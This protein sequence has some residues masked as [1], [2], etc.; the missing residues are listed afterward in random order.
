MTAAIIDT[1]V[2]FRVVIFQITHSGLPKLSVAQKSSQ[3]GTT[4]VFGDCAAV[5]GGETR[6]AKE[7]G[8]TTRYVPESTLS[9]NYI[10]PLASHPCSVG[11]WE[12]AVSITP[13]IYQQTRDPRTPSL[14]KFAAVTDREVSEEHKICQKPIP[15]SAESRSIISPPFP[16]PSR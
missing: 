7:V 9:L 15:F 12:K 10:N 16:A 3:N 1:S 14:G 11:R 5:A 8:E 2:H 13:S 4:L 6:G